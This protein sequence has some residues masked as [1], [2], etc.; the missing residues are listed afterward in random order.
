ME[1]NYRNRNGIK[2]FK[3]FIVAIAFLYLIL[4]P[5][6][7]SITLP[8]KSIVKTIETRVAGKETQIKTY[9]TKIGDEK[10]IINTLTLGLDALQLQLDSI[11]SIRD[12]VKIIQVQ[13]TVIHEYKKLTGNL[14][15]TVI[16]QDSVITSQRYVITSK[17]TLLSMNKVELKRIKRQRNTSIL[18]GAAILAGTIAI[19][20]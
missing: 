13:D 19:I 2:L 11:R 6:P 5:A 16:I 7:E 20:K 12:T 14:T 15:K 9:L 8:G 3:Q 18:I 17:D 10:K 1:F 4:R